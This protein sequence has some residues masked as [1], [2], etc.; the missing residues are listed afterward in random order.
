MVDDAHAL[1]VLGAR[2]FGSAEH[3]GIDP[4]RGR[5]LDGDAEQEPRVVQ[6][7]ISRA[8]TALI[9]Q[10]KRRCRASCFRSGWRRRR[11]LRRWPRWRF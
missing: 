6:A 2:G 8:P 4:A 5:Y 10:L 7:A 11:P 1:G 3:A 9:G